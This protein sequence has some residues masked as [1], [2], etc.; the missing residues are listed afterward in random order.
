MAAAYLESIQ[1]EL[2]DDLSFLLWHESLS[3][4]D[5]SFDVDRSP[6][7]PLQFKGK[8]FP[9]NPADAPI[10]YDPAGPPEGRQAFSLFENTGYY[11]KVL[12]TAGNELDA[13]NL[14]STLQ[15]PAESR[16]KAE[17]NFTQLKGESLAGRFKV[18]NYLGTA[19]IGRN[20]YGPNPV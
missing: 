18:S 16:R 9:G 19:E 13:S 1:I 2:A 12:G 11:W 17:W 5:S 14:T 8:S 7:P 6:G 15:F 3:S 20:N 4:P 10:I